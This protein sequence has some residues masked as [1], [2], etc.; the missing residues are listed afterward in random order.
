MTT[1]GAG[2]RYDLRKLSRLYFSSAKTWWAAAL[3]CK[4]GGI[5]VSALAV[6][7]F[8]SGSRWT[9]GLNSEHSLVPLG[10]KDDH[11]HLE[12]CLL[13]ERELGAEWTRS[14]RKTKILVP[15]LSPIEP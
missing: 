6:P 4:A 7:L 12:M 8:G 13:R 3:W 2:A 9:D 5:V 15:G 14:K 11:H 10:E 1:T